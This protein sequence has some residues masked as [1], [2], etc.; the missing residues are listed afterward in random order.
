M[1]IKFHH[2]ANVVGN[3]PTVRE[4]VIAIEGIMRE[5]P[6]VEIE[7]VHHFSNGI[8]AR[9]ARIPAGVTLTGEIHKYPQLNILSK[10]RISVLTDD[11]MKEVEAPFTINSPA[12]TKRIAYTHT[13]C[14]W[15]TILH[16]F[17]T[18]PNLIYDKFIAKNEDDWLEFAG[19]K[20]LKLGLY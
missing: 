2:I 6:Q 4:Q 18:D 13:D 19:L 17:E 7:I 1:D 3:R 16:T 10:G 14:V 12:G 9:E 8:Y 15:T 5:M 20:Q 11:G